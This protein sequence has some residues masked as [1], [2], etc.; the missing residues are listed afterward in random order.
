LSAT[1]WGIDWWSYLSPIYDL[2]SLFSGE[3]GYIHPVLRLIWWAL[4]VIRSDTDSENVDQMSIS[5]YFQACHDSHRTFQ[6]PFRWT[7]PPCDVPC[8]P[9]R[10]ISFEIWFMIPFACI[11][12]LN[13]LLQVDILGLMLLWFPSRGVEDPKLITYLFD[14]SKMGWWLNQA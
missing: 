12:S 11:A 5:R 1:N 9:D 7:P 14:V 3:A 13:L 8:K 10:P 4:S 2:I 6:S